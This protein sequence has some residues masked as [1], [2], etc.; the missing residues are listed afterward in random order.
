MISSKAVAD[1]LGKRHDNFMRDIKKYVNTLGEE[2]SK[3]FV[4]G[5][6][7]DGLG[8]ER[9]CYDCTLAG[10]DLIAGR[11]IGSKSEEFKAKYLPLFGGEQTIT[12]PEVTAP[13]QEEIK[14]L[15]L[16][17]V[18]KELGCSERTVRRMIQR[19]DLH[20]TQVTILIPTERTMVTLE[21]LE[22]YKAG[23]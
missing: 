15:T 9:A 21:E 1:M 6:Y 10:C 4:E 13:V 12:E 18:A 14:A 3:Y 19:G 5:T 8:K 7:K 20:S 16:D 2:A 11:I 23:R 17:D 22:R